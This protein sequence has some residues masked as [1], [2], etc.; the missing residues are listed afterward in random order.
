MDQPR[1]PHPNPFCSLI[2]ERTMDTLSRR[3]KKLHVAVAQELGIPV[4][5]ERSEANPVNNSGDS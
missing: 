3:L 4:G 2:E 1:I 5:T